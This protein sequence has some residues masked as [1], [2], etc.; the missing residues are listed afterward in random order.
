[1]PIADVS[2]AILPEL[3]RDWGRQEASMGSLEQLL[4]K[5]CGWQESD[6]LALMKNDEA[7]SL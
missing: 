5:A 1:M 4:R 6:R 7:S 2:S 3:F